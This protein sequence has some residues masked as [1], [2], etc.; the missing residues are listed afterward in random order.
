MSAATRAKKVFGPDKTPEVR[1]PI[2]AALRC[3]RG[4]DRPTHFSRTQRGASPGGVEVMSSTRGIVSL[5]TSEFNV[6]MERAVVLGGEHALPAKKQLRDMSSVVG[7]RRQA[8]ACAFDLAVRPHSWASA[9]CTSR[10]RL[11]G[12]HRPR[13]SRCRT[14]M[15]GSRRFPSIEPVQSPRRTCRGSPGCSPSR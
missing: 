14:Q 4:R 12:D 13:R 1:K 15:S 9:T 6:S 8:H 5:R 3:A 11:P 10:S 7:L 2:G